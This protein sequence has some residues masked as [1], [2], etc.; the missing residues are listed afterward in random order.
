M[1]VFDQDTDPGPLRGDTASSWPARFPGFGP[2]APLDMWTATDAEVAGMRARVLDGSWRAF[3]ETAAKVGNCSAPIRLAGTS[4]TF[5]NL[6]GQPGALLSE[7]SHRD[8]PLGTLHVACGNRRAEVC[9]ACSRVYARDTFEMIRAGVLGGKTVP[10]TVAANPL[11][12]ATFT[13]PSFGHVHGLRSGK[14]GAP[15]RCR[16][17]DTAKRCPH[18]RPVGCNR[19]HGEED[20]MLGAPLCWDC[21]DFT[22]AVVWQWWAPE[23][24]RRFTITFK[25]RLAARL[26]VSQAA[27]ARSASVQFAKVAEYQRRGLVH[28]HALIRLDGPDGPGSPAPL[29][30]DALA[31]V[32]AETGPLVVFDAPP[33]DGDDITRT[34]RFGAQLDVK[35]VRTGQ[36]HNP[37]GASSDRLRPEQVAGYLA[38]YS[39]KSTGVDPAAPTPHLARLEREARYLADRA[40][41]TCRDTATPEEAEDDGCVCGRCEDSPYRLLAKWSRMLGFRGHFSSKSR[42]YSISLG[43]LRRARARFAR[44]SAEADRRG[45]R[46]DLA[47]LEACLLADDADDETTLVIGAWTYAG[48]GWTNPGDKALADA[49]ADRARQ[50]DQWRAQ[51]RRNGKQTTD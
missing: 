42:A 10:D 27:F 37:A 6:N 18:G 36:V 9:P 13:A 5:E 39:T 23:L 14:N 40:A 26:G 49:A 30:G 11:V 44:L 31:A 46:L 47:D 43:R 3:A 16:P 7:F 21:Y 51:Q 24:W 41:S 1:R 32:V 12:F 17:R 29:D 50:Y 8:T 19:V 38:K 25:R 4:R 22:S 34:L 33:V 28:F 15:G 2:D 35:R 45:E 48:T 20:P